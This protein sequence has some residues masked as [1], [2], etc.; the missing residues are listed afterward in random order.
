MSGSKAT[1]TV[2]NIHD[3]LEEFDSFTVEVVVDKAQQNL[4]LAV[5]FFREGED[6]QSVLSVGKELPTNSFVIPLT[7]QQAGEMSLVLIKA[8]SEMLK[9]SEAAKKV[10]DDSLTRN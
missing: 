5:S 8:V 10:L 9:S 6:P 4:G 7:L 2:E 1:T 3:V